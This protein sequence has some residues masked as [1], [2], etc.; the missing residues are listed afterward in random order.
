MARPKYRFVFIYARSRT[1]QS[2][3]PY[4]FNI[5]LVMHLGMRV[6]LRVDFV[7]VYEFKTNIWMRSRQ[8]VV[9]LLNIKFDKN[10]FLVF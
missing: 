8:S 3:R 4:A 10:L 1:C 6:T 7:L 2:V 9:K 5:S